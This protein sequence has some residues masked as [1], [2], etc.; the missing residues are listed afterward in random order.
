MMLS[1]I[2]IDNCKLRRFLTKLKNLSKFV[3]FA[4][5]VKAD[6]LMRVTRNSPSHEERVSGEGPRHITVAT[7]VCNVLSLTF[8]PFGTRLR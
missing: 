3:M 2:E 4:G 6:G 5:Y 1:R 8:G 7:W